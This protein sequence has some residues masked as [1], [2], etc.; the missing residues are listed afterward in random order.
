GRIR[1]HDTPKWV[2]FSLPDWR[3][4]RTDM[5]HW[6]RLLSRLLIPGTKNHVELAPPDRRVPGL[7]GPLSHSPPL[8]QP[9]L[10]APLSPQ[11]SSLASAPAFLQRSGYR[12][13]PFAV[14]AL[15][16]AQRLLR[17]GEAAR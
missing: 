10:T 5:G 9:L 15:A 13:I 3:W 14:G 2:R 7:S 11:P 1:A 8:A 12:R 6:L 4:I 16:R 17:H